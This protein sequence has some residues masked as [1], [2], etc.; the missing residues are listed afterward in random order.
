M[1]HEAASYRTFA[2]VIASSSSP[3]HECRAP[4]AD[5]GAKDAAG[6]DAEKCNKSQTLISYEDSAIVH[7]RTHS[8][9]PISWRGGEGIGVGDGF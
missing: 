8:S 3:G 2:K 6:P 5:V 7:L 4:A 1:P 9:P